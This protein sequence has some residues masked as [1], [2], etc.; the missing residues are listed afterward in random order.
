ME[1][2]LIGIAAV[3]IF[4]LLGV[5]LAFATLFVGAAGI[6]YLRGVD[7]AV[8][9]T[10]Q[11]IVE[12]SMNYGLSV[13]PLF[14]LMGAFI[15]RSGIS[16]ELYDAS[17]AWLGHFRGGL[18]MATVFACA[19]FAAV[20]GSSLAT[21]ATMGRVAMPPM[22]KFNYNDGLS[23]GTIAAGGTLGIMIPPSVPM[24]IY[25]I[26]V[27]ADIGALF[28]AGVLPG[29][30]LVSLFLVAVAILVRI[31][32]ELGPAGERLS[33]SERFR[34]SLGVYPVIG[35]FVIVLGGIYTGVFTPTESAAVGAVGAY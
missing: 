12:S 13:V 14:I 11:W 3:L 34:K 27:S 35:L 29:L 6:A 26:I 10:G 9:I 23:T 30:L 16:E 4:S 5:P 20:C 21:A 28:I 31:R 33:L 17:Y 1:L 7:A 2:A 19:G 24:V 18:A 22:R 25:A 8:G 15:H 32:P